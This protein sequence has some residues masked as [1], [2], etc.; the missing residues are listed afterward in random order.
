MNITITVNLMLDAQD[1]NV[2]NID[3]ILV[4]YPIFKTQDEQVDLD[5]GH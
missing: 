4:I 1:K 3:D 5:I 2:A